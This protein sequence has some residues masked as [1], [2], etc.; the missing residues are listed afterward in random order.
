MQKHSYNLC[1]YLSKNGVEVLLYHCIPSDQS[2]PDALTGF[3]KDELLNIKSKCFH[4]PK[5]KNFP[6][7]YLRESYELSQNYYS[8]YREEAGVDL[9]Y[10]QGF[11]AWAFLKNKESIKQPI[12][13]NFHG[14]EMFQKA[15]SIKAKLEHYLLRPTV[16]YHLKYAD[17]II[18]LGGKLT[19]LIA[20]KINPDKIIV[21]SIGIEADWLEDKTSINAIR[22]FVFIGRN[23]RRKGI[24]ELNQI[25]SSIK[26]STFQL[27]VIGPFDYKDQIN[28]KRV[29]YHGEIKEQMIIASILSKADIL[30]L[31]SWSEGMPTVIL[32]AMAKGCAILA[33]DVGAVAELVD[34]SNGWL[35]EVGNLNSMKTNFVNAIHCSDQT[36][37]TLRKASIAKVRARYTWEMVAD[38]LIQQLKTLTQ[39]KGELH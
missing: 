15:A 28:D 2:F 11:T 24:K 9:I 31:P 30:V 6:G 7:H 23:E 5:K 26:D 4:F 38:D 33:N 34:E 32:E 21:N 35:C 17:Y 22:H 1:K 25:I 16:L 8:S 29:L 39:K 12:V 3:T 27:D 36:L 20:T 13:S 37:L 14:L 18:S 19:E 10:A